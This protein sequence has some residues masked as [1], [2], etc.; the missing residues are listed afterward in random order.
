M[1]YGLETYTSSGALSFSSDTKPFGL[2]DV[3]VT[4]TNSNGS[5]AYP[6]LAGDQIEIQ[7]VNRRGTGWSAS[8]LPYDF[9]I[10]YASGYPVISWT[11]NNAYRIAGAFYPPQN[12]YVILKTYV[13]SEYGFQVINDN[14]EI[15]SSD[16]TANYKYIGQATLTANISGSPYVDYLMQCTIT[17]NSVPV[18]F[19]ENLEG[20]L[21]TVVNM[22][23]SGTTYTI[24]INKTGAAIPRVFC[25]ERSTATP[26]GYGIAIFNESS[27]LLMDSTNNLLAPKCYCNAI[28]PST[29]QSGSDALYTIPSTSLLTPSGTIPTNAATCIT[30]NAFY[31]GEVNFVGNRYLKDASLAVKK[32]SGNLYTGWTLSNFAIYPYNTFYPIFMNSSVNFRIYSIDISQYV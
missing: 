9:S 10:S 7:I 27:S 1:T 5:Q 32:Q 12:V 8:T 29:A 21:A 31:G 4:G 14:S 24:T 19:I 30:A 20:Q 6:E 3:F 2:Y 18:I 17:S 11:Y 16:I 28:I 15:V 25:F 23:V 22:T 13:S 26:T